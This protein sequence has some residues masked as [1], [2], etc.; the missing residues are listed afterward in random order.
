MTWCADRQ[1]GEHLAI[2]L[3]LYQSDLKDG[4][5]RGVSVEFILL[6][7]LGYV[8]AIASLITPYQ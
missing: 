3:I 8:N 4:K 5:N 1:G 6:G 7:D 2:V